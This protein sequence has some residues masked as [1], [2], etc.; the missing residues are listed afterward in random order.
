M[1]ISSRAAHILSMI[2]M[3][4]LVSAC[5]TASA[6][7]WLDRVKDA[8][9]EE[10]EDSSTLT[11]D[12]VGGGLKEALR[13]GTENVVVRVGAPD[14]FNLDPEI[15]IPLPKDLDKVR[16][17]LVRIGAES[18][19]EDLETRLN[20]AAEVATPKAK[21]LFL[22][23]IKDMTLHDVMDIY[24]GPDDAATQ[25]FMSR[26]SEPLAAA[27]NPIVEDALS[28]VGAAQSYESVM[29]RYNSLPFVPKAEADL[30]DYVVAKGMDG[31]FFYLAREEAA[32]RKDPAKRTTD[33]LRRVFGG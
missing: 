25:Y 3:A 21:Q 23:A 27:M 13:V 1:I 20:R 2:L 32:I 18:M 24:N 14:G 29:R 16:Q 4:A 22:G 26:M 19:L 11:T 15:H 30:S 33:L 31:I 7:G 12:E 10:R 9:L 28:D 17:V 8:V 5:S 6:G